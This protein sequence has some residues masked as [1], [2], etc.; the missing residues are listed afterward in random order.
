MSG[1]RGRPRKYFA[2]PAEEYAHKVLRGEMVAGPYVRKACERHL[3]DLEEQAKRG[4]LWDWS[5]GAGRL[6]LLR[7]M[8]AAR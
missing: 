2:D 3:R 6:R 7:E 4:I 1:N 8:P 5:K